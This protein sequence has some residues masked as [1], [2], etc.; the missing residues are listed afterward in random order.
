MGKEY[1]EAVKK[2]CPDYAVVAYINTTAEL[3]TIC[4]VCVTSSCAV[5]LVK[6]LPEKKCFIYTRLQ[7]RRLC[8][9]AGPGKES[10][11]ASREDALCMHRF[12]LLT[13][14]VRRS[15]HPGAEVLVHPECRQ[16]VLAHADF[17]GSTSAIMNYAVRSEGTEFI[18]GTEISIAQHLSYQCPEKH[19]YAL[20]KCLI[21]PD[22]KETS[23]MDVY[24]AA[25][26]TGGEEIL[27]D[28]ETIEKAGKCIARMIELG[29]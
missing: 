29:G 8:G 14:N 16:E 13:W 10:E 3:K 21:C 22:M 20:S 23:L 18:I 15:F 1:I 19:F 27:L 4:D 12:V 28:E 9:R 24:H 25:A 7:P 5:E 6:K 26:G 17:I 2:E 11:A